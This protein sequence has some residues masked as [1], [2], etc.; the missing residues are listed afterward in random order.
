[1]SLKRMKKSYFHLLLPLLLFGLHACQHEEETVESAYVEPLLPEPAYKFSR[2]GYSSV[3]ILEPSFL[4]K[5]LD[6]LYGHIMREAR[7]SIAGEYNSG[8]SYYNKGEFGLKPIEHVAQSPRHIAQS[9]VYRK[10]LLALI[11]A[12]AALSGYPLPEPYVHRNRNA[13]IGRSGF[14]GHDIGDDNKFFIDEKGVAVAEVFKYYAM[15]AIYLDKVLNMHLNEELFKNAEL[16]RR[17]QNVSIVKGRN[18]TELEHHLDLAYGY[19]KHWQP[20]TRAEGLPILKDSDHKIF[21]ALVQA[22]TS[23]QYYRYDEVL[24][25]IAIVREE[26]SKVVPIRIMNLLVGANTLANIEEQPEYAFDFLSQA[27]GL[28][29]C[30]PFTL[31]AD[32]KPYFTYG[33][34]QTLIADLLQG[35]G[36]WETE[37]LL[38]D[39]KRVGSLKNIATRVGQPFNIT[40]Q[41]IKR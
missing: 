3:D 10:D 30:L 21:I 34:S 24:K 29:R 27:I 14:V 19:Y 6:Y 12:S 4:K 25:Q 2:H 33:E 9:A 37:R 40:L 20:L 39:E 22:R 23:L 28:M 1:M 41:N 7:M 8:L 13:K 15:G 18:Y 36:L 5:T 16:I 26:L 31:N 32:G 38:G 11:D 17:H 35:Q